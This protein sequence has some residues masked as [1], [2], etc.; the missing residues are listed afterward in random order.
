M[1]RFVLLSCNLIKEFQRRCPLDGATLALE[2]LFVLY[3]EKNIVPM[4]L[5]DFSEDEIVEPS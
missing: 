4:I 1:G 5:K 3:L 2:F